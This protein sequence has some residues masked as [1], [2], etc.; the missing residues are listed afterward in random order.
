MLCLLN[1]EDLLARDHPLRAIK[2]L[3]DVALAAMSPFLDAMYAET[4]RASVPPEVLLKARL[5][6]HDAAGQFF[7]TVVEQAKAK[8]LMSEEHFS[9]DGTLIE[10]WASMKSFR[11]KDDDD[12]DQRCEHAAGARSIGFSSQRLVE[13]Q[14]RKAQQRDA[15]VEDRPG[16][17]ARTKGKRP[18]SEA[19]LQRPRHDGEQERSPRRRSCAGSER[20]GRARGGTRHD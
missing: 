16:G 5:L 3:S 2:A 7:A 10:A 12:R 1:A 20:Q 13:L 9:V 18:R 6:A 17:E 11:P 14:R 8:G 19:L 4:G 15:R